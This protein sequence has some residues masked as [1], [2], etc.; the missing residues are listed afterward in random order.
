MG[1][2]IFVPLGS[3]SLDAEALG[4]LTLAR[5]VGA[6]QFIARDVDVVG[7]FAAQAGVVLQREH[8]RRDRHQLA[9]LEDQERIARDLHDTVIQRLFATGLSLQGASRVIED[10]DARH[11]VE[12]AVDDLDLTV[13]HI[14][15]VIFDVATPRLGAESTRGRMLALARRRTRARIQARRRVPRTRR[16]PDPRRCR[17]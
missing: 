11:R 4:A 16:Q 10:V 15:T 14:R 9:R 7:H 6:A 8:S 5:T 13:R 3:S 17:R 1:P 12:S 2:A